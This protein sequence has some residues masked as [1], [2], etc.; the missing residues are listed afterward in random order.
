MV[1]HMEYRA[2]HK[3]SQSLYMEEGTI[4]TLPNLSKFL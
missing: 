3:N 1:E 4:K 2:R